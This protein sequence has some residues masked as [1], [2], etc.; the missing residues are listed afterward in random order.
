MSDVSIFFF[1]SI[2]D[3]A[4]FQNDEGGLAPD[5]FIEKKPCDDMSADERWG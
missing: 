2:H 3:G 5:V 1:F 4:R